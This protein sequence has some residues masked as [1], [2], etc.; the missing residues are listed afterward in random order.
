MRSRNTKM[1]RLDEVAS[2]GVI[3]VC[4]KRGHKVVLRNIA[5]EKRRKTRQDNIVLIVNDSPWQIPVKVCTQLI[6]VEDEVEEKTSQRKHQT[7]Q[8]FFL[9]PSVTGTRFVTY[10]VASKVKCQ[11][12]SKN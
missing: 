8:S 4:G 6:I 3:M 9:Q 12:K 10:D 5:S 2:E 1:T 7:N 11:P